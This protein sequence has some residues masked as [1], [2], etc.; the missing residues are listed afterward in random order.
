MSIQLRLIESGTWILSRDGKEIGQ[1]ECHAQH[2][3][4]FLVRKDETLSTNEKLELDKLIL[5]IQYRQG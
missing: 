5:G 1:L 3:V 4:Q 2:A